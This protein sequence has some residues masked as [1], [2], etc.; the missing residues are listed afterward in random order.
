MARSRRAYFEKLLVA[1]PDNPD[2]GRF[3]VRDLLVLRFLPPVV[4]DLFAALRFGR[5]DLK[6]ISIQMLKLMAPRA[7][8]RH[9][10]RIYALLAFI[11]TPGMSRVLNM[12]GINLLV[13]RRLRR[14]ENW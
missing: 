3:Y 7:R 8:L 1:F 13:N 9:R 11:N 14:L 12:P 10:L 6:E 5:T 4:H 2:M